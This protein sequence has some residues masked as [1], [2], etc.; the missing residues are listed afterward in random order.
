MVSGVTF[1]GMNTP[2]LLLVSHILVSVV[3][4]SLTIAIAN[5]YYQPITT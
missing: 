3:L 1:K 4:A 2:Y 5:F